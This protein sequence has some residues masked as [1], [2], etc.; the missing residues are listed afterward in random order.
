[1]FTMRIFVKGSYCLF[2]QHSAL[3]IAGVQRIAFVPFAEHIAHKLAYRFIVPLVP[4]L[5]HHIGRLIWAEGG[6]LLSGC[7][8]MR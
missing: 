1:M 6:S 7:H 5:Q 8:D 4:R 3:H 2:W